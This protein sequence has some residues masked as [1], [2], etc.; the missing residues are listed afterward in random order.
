VYRS[1]SRLD[2]SQ[3]LWSGKGLV[4]RHFLAPKPIEALSGEF[5]IEVFPDEVRFARETEKTQRSQQRGLT[6]TKTTRRRAVFRIQRK[7][8]KDL[9]FWTS[10][11][12][13]ET[14]LEVLWAA[15]IGGV[16]LLVLGAFL[17]GTASYDYFV[18][19]IFILFAGMVLL[20]VVIVSYESGQTRME[21]VRKAYPKSG[22]EVLIA[23]HSGLS[24][25]H[26]LLTIRGTPEIE[27]LYRIL[28]T[29]II[30]FS[31][32]ASRPPMDST[33]PE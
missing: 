11:T 1:Q 13:A 23:Y 33:L 2:R 3:P 7:S 22:A 24:G 18:F 9:A 32:E 17:V 4:A 16:A 20:G 14:S 25:G 28:K 29:N 21:E 31:Q 10:T 8:I 12:T 26:Q 19:G 15:V 27:G 5:E 30:P 6:V